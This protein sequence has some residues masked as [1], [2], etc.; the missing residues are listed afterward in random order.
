MKF[1]AVLGIKD[2]SGRKIKKYRIISET[3]EIRDVPISKIKEVLQKEITIE[4]LKI[5]DGS[6]TETTEIPSITEL[7]Q[8]SL[9]LEE[10]CLQNGERGQRILTE[11]NEGNNFP[12]A[13][14]DI[15]AH[16]SIKAQFRCTVCEKINIQYISNKTDTLDSK[17]KYC[18]GRENIHG[19]T[20]ITLLDWCKLHGTYGTQ[21]L[22]EFINGDNDFTPDQVSYA[23]GQYA[24]FRCST[25]GNINRQIIENKTRQNVAGCKYCDKTQTSFGEQ[26]VYLWL[27]SQGFE[28]YNQYKI[29]T[30]I[31]AKEFDIFIPIL[32]LAIE[33]QS[34][35]H[36]TTERQFNDDIT[37]LIAQQ[38]GFNLLEICKTDSYYQR[39]ESNWCITYKQ[40]HESEMI[41]KLSNWLNTN[42]GL[43][44]NPKYPRALEDQAYINSCKVKSK[45]SLAYYNP[46]FLSE[47]NQ[48]LNGLITP[49]KVALNS[50]RKYYWN[51]PICGHIYL[52][53][54]SKRN[55]GR[56]C[57]NWR[58]HTTR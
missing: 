39:Q 16:S 3:N 24:N 51:C 49:D 47:W 40:N 38:L 4:G 7:K 6:I 28:V 29:K 43:N 25:C 17:C 11:F 5:T 27:L 46:L 18:A 15:S 30:P 42:Y 23:S 12:I 54:P 14:K 48:E 58:N 55:Q 44:T 13:A 9:S 53:S 31:G 45:Q 8:G 50:N 34:N 2:S 41:T 1:K 32:N 26:I 36:R 22:Q 56:A 20:G 33:H 35:Q 57:P 21:L 52:A 37:E 19:Q 10:W